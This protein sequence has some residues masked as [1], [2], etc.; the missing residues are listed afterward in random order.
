[1]SDLEILEKSIRDLSAIKVPAA[2]TEE[3][4]IPIY[5]SVNML[6][7]LYNTVVETINKHNKEEMHVAEEEPQPEE[8]P[9]SEEATE[10]N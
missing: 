7:N 10:E 9:A 6:R 1:M 4:A 5:N 2:L 8:E 3:I